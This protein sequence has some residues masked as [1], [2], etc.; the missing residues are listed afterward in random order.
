MTVLRGPEMGSVGCK[1]SRLFPC[2]ES[3]SGRDI[4]SAVFSAIALA[5]A[6]IAISLLVPL[7]AL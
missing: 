7:Q 3:G 1:A 4:Q 2:T 6:L 5:P